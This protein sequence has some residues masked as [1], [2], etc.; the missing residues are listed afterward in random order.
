MADFLTIGEP[1]A[2]FASENIDKSLSES[3]DFKKYTAGAELNVAVGVARLGHSV[4][5]IS[6]IGQDFIGDFILNELGKNGVGRKYINIS[7]NY[8]TGFYFKQS[9]SNGDPKIE[10]YRKNS[11]SSHFDI[12]KIDEIDFDSVKLI[13]VS[14]IMAA[15]SEDGL[16]AVK[17]ILKIANE[18]NIITTFDPNIR[19][20]LWES[21][22]QMI[23]TLNLLAKDSTVIL[24]GINE[25]NIL[26]GCDS[27]EDI[28]DYY[29]NSGGKTETV[30][31]KD[32]SKG[33]FCK[34]KHGKAIHL[35]A[36]KV[37]KVVDT[38]GAGDGFAVGII[39]AMLENLSLEDTLKRA[40][41]IGS[42]AVQK[43][44]DNSGYPTRKELEDFIEK[45]SI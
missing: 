40:C 3:C 26:T 1:M 20:N 4:E 9:V 13:H 11:A 33:A 31:V 14:G 35:K 34:T 2:V 21:K 28:A 16:N 18:K 5:Y 25:G 37:E 8:K 7:D 17:K 39:T 38:V 6:Q 27:V 10:Y 22:Q 24:P 45:N 44:G 15:I 41:I 29:L 32:G 36:F 23:D 43:K 30:I 12:S 19:E 42:L